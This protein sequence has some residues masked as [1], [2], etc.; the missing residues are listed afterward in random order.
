MNFSKKIINEIVKQ[1][2]DDK[3]PVNCLTKMFS[4][5]K[6][7]AY[8]RIRNQIP[9]SIEEVVA[10]AKNYDLSVDELLELRPSN[11]FLFNKNLNI[12]QN[13]EDIY[14]DLL[15][16]GIDI[17]NKLIVSKNAKITVILNNIPLRFFP[18]KSL[19]KLDYYHYM[20]SI[21]K[22][23][24]VTTLYSDIELPSA[25]NDLHDK[26]ASCFSRLNNITCIVDSMLYSNIIKKIEYYHQ[27]KVISNEDLRVLQS[28][29]FDL[30]ALYENL[31]R[32]GSNNSGSGYIFYYSCFNL[33]SN[34]IFCEYDNNSL[35]QFWI[36]PESPVIIKNNPQICDIH[37]RWIDSKLRNSMLITRTSDI[38]QIEMLR[39]V[40]QQ[41]SELTHATNYSV[42]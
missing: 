15:K 10:I 7:T 40:H 36:Y 2:P 22:I 33:E 17:M 18:Y 37:K 29:L 35:L 31:L 1:S 4:M 32:N 13:T 28:E 6:E 39:R 24:L 11:N 26:S 9:F 34:S 19:L 25:I 5:S 12:E 30:L 42:I 20:Y 27:L 23:S 14:A 38:H 41:I 21:G 3:S 16:S 8:R